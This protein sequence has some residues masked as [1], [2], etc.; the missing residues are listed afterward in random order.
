MALPVVAFG[1]PF[2]NE[3]REILSRSIIFCSVAFPH[4]IMDR[5]DDP[6]IARDAEL[7]P[8]HLHDLVVTDEQRAAA[9]KDRPLVNPNPKFP[10]AKACLCVS[11]RRQAPRRPWLMAEWKGTNGTSEDPKS[12]LSDPPVQSREKCILGVMAVQSFSRIRVSLVGCCRA[13]YAA[14]RLHVNTTTTTSPLTGGGDQ[15]YQWT[16]TGYPEERCATIPAERTQ[17][18]L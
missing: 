18:T 2:T 6:N 12:A 11:A 4:R 7:V 1:C 8:D 5:F 13:G 14:P 3:P 17:I 10:T 15:G 9:V 16:R